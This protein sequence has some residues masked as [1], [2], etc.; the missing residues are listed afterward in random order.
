MRFIHI[1]EY[2]YINNVQCIISLTRIGII[3]HVSVKAITSKL[4]KSWDVIQSLCIFYIPQQNRHIAVVI[5][6][7]HWIGVQ[8]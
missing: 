4:G 1:N 8:L 2:E 3:S 6:C 7:S 5:V